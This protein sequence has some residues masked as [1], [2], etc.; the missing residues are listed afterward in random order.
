[1]RISEV[2]INNPGYI[3]NEK[4]NWEEYPAY[5]KEDAPDIDTNMTGL[6]FAKDKNSYGVLSMS[7][8]TAMGKITYPKARTL[9]ALSPGQN[10][11]ISFQIIGNETKTY[12][13]AD[14]TN[15]KNVG[16]YKR[17]VLVY[18]SMDN[19]N[20]YK[21]AR[22]TI[23]FFDS[24]LYDEK[25]VINEIM[26]NPVAGG[27]NE[28]IE[29][30]NPTSMAID[31][32]E[33]II[34]EGSPSSVIKLKGVEDDDIGLRGAVIPSNGYA[35]FCNSTRS[36]YKNFTFGTDAV[37]F[38]Y[39]GTPLS[40]LDDAGD[41]ITLKNK[42]YDTVDSVTYS[43]SWGGNGNNETLERNETGW[44][45]SNTNGKNGTL[46]RRNSISDFSN[47]SLGNLISVGPDRY[48]NVTAGIQYVLY[49]ITVMNNGNINDTI[50]ISNI[51]ELGWNVSIV[52][53]SGGTANWT[54]PDGTI[55]VNLN[56]TDNIFHIYATLRVNITIPDTF[57]GDQSIAIV[58]AV[59]EKYSMA[60][61]YT[62]FDTVSL[63]TKIL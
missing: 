45:Q 49:N 62:V 52:W 7:K 40:N 61:N 12:W 35:V 28:W 48:S 11:N 34:S 18:D 26:Y 2:L 14:Y 43:S 1:M 37:W 44:F 54:N 27:D 46:G 3:D 50:T 39:I 57:S 60:Y 38:T 29:L 22:L 63:L 55:A 32:T 59:S 20:P 9:L 5:Y 33:W 30:Y 6:G 15:A 42:Y 25:I 47:P 31:V 16:M 51:S 21:P 58:T 10:F 24:G 4:T 8:I 17:I 36:V 41:T 53:L 23:C 19:E 13:G 56:L